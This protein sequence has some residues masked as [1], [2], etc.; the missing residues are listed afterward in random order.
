MYGSSV[1]L[2]PPT[3]IEEGI[4]SGL[5]FL[6]CFF[7]YI[8]VKEIQFQAF[9]SSSHNSTVFIAQNTAK[10][11]TFFHGILNLFL[12]LCYHHFMVTLQM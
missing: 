1:D 4:K 6:T 11:Y 2:R 3:V 12:A 9:S 10:N 5:W 7:D 8:K